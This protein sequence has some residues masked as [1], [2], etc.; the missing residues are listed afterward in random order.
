MRP[1]EIWCLGPC[2]KGLLREGVRVGMKV[3]NPYTISSGL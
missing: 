1:K 2:G 3:P